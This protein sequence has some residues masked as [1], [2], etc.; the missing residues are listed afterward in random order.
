MRLPWGSPPIWSCSTAPMR[1][2]RCRRLRPRCL[3]S[4][5][6]AE[7]FPARQGSFIRHA[8]MATDGLPAQTAITMESGGHACGGSALLFEQLL[9]LQLDAIAE[10]TAVAFAGLQQLACL[11]GRLRLDAPLFGA[12]DQHR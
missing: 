11:F 8:D 7:H 12:G 5:R 10:M 6:G 9:E 4:R 1:R 3:V 2:Q